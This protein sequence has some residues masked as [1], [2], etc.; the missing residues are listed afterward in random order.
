MDFLTQDVFDVLVLAN[1]AVGLLIAARKFYKD[2]NG[3]LPYD[4]PAWARQKYDQSTDSTPSS[5][6]S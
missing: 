4:A 6:N 1:I 2:I 3:P 5:D